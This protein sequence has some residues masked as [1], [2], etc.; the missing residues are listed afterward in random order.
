MF[1]AHISERNAVFVWGDT[2][3]VAKIIGQLSSWRYP[4]KRHCRRPQNPSLLH[5]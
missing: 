4:A 2:K 5:E 1:P 3:M